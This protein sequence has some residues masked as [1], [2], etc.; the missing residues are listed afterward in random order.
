M[1]SQSFDADPI[2][3]R[4]VSSTTALSSCATVNCPPI[5]KVVEKECSCERSGPPDA[6][7]QRAQRQWGT[8]WQLRCRVCWV[9]C[10]Q[11]LRGRETRHNGSFFGGAEEQNDTRCY[12]CNSGSAPQCDDKNHSWCAPP[13]WTFASRVSPDP[14]Y[15]SHPSGRALPCGKPPRLQSLLRTPRPYPPL[16]GH[17]VETHSHNDQTNGAFGPGR[18]EK[19]M[20]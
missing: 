6:G 15:L 3:V 11:A 10:P 19:P 13:P 9:I 8:P 7:F 5:S 17:L 16:R 4:P 2:G 14:Y 20:Y 1:A 12:R 18:V